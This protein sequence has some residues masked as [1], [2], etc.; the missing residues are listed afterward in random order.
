MADGASDDG[1]PHIWHMFG[2]TGLLQR[3][4]LVA[5]MIDRVCSRHLQD[6]FEMSVAQWRVLAF[7]CNAGPATAS[8]IGE[9]A[10]ADQAE[11][12]RAVKALLARQ[13]VTRDYEP[14]SR[15]TLII[16]PTAAGTTLF[17]QVRERRQSYF[18]QITGTLDDAQR[19]ALNGGL[20][21]L[22]RAVIVERA[23]TGH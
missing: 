4:L 8:F 5:K 13:L 16:A 9:A 15:K 2:D 22:A 3:L 10:E 14:G 1:L 18:A 20:R 11:I 23:G 7:I 6:D 19:S 17:H 12:S 21:N